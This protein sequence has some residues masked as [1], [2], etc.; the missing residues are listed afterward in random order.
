MH[1]NQVV[2]TMFFDKEP[3]LSRLLERLPKDAM[4]QVLEEPDKL[5]ADVLSSLDDI[6]RGNDT[7]LCCF[8][9]NIGQLSGYAQ[10]VLEYT[11]LIPVGYVTTYGALADVAGGS[12]RSVGNVEA[13]NMVPLL[14][15]CHRV[16]RSDLTVG[17]YGFGAN[18]KFEILKQEDKGYEESTTVTV[19]DKKLVLFPVKWVKK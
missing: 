3:D 9:V 13:S 19:D 16:V 12:A 1:D 17:G 18:V 7:K 4:F 2:A 11:R 10:R 6:F 5:L 14:I 8:K 15:P